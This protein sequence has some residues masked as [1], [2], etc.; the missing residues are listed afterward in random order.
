MSML[1]LCAVFDFRTVDMEINQA[2]R[3]YWL[4]KSGN[5][6]Q[7]Q[8]Q[9]RTS[10]GNLS[11][12]QQQKWLIAR[13][14]DLAT[15][16]GRPVRALEFGCGFGRFARL[17]ANNPHIEY[18]GYDFSLPMV[19][20]LFDDPPPSFN[21]SERV[22]VAPTVNEAF[23]D[24]KFDVIFTVSVLIHNQQEKAKQLCA[25][26]AAMLTEEGQLWL[27]ENALTALSTRENNWHGGC[28]VHDY[29]GTTAADM[30]I[31]VYHECIL[32]HS[33][34]VLQ[35]LSQP[36]KI[37]LAIGE[38]AQPRT[39]SLE[40][41]QQLGLPRLQAAIT[42]LDNE[43]AGQA[44]LQAMSH[45]LGEKVRS[46]T[47]EIR[48]LKEAATEA[49]NNLGEAVGSPL[50]SS[51]INSSVV[52]CTELKCR[53]ASANE[54]LQQLRSAKNLRS[55]IVDALNVAQPMNAKVDFSLSME[56]LTA[57][58]SDSVFD[59]DASQDLYLANPHEDF[60]SV[61]H[62][63]NREW[64]G[65]RAAAGALPGHKLA[66]SAKHPISA[67]DVARAVELLESHNI[68]KLVLQGMS[69]SMHSL[70]LGLA[71]KG[72]FDLFLVWHGAPAMWLNE[73]ERKLVGFAIELTRRGVIK[74]M[75]GMR[76]GT[77]PLIGDRAYPKLLLN[78]PPRI[79][80][81][82]PELTNRSARTNRV[83]F[84]PS[85][86][87][88]HKNVASSTLA[89]HVTPEIKEIWLLDDTVAKLLKYNSKV[90]TLGPRSGRA[91]LQTM[92]QADVVINVSLIDCHPM[93]DLEALAVGTPCVRGPLFLDA[94]EE[95]PYVRLTEVRN[96]LSVSDISKTITRIMQFPSNEL[97]AMMTD[98]RQ[99]LGKV[100]LSRYREFLEL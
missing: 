67:A 97:S 32:N 70:I 24:R 4:S 31:C 79:P 82:M 41:L 63:F 59:W 18:Y 14:D 47:E 21:P 27:I 28:W 37:E 87:L 35:P 38:N 95:H 2:N 39:S 33:A 75:H 43:V 90:K 55:K 80:N 56:K 84:I 60:D 1:L 66:I 29:A 46:L 62:V 23:G 72:K 65:I 17:F 93:V 68:K 13:F 34:Y 5:D 44:Q 77:E 96:I 69:E 25:E 54:Q 9:E 49:L 53:T 51:E 78:M 20:P 10:Q 16:V 36:R 64:I 12:T 58:P 40:E 74:G 57:I 81:E 86:H 89:A 6:Y 76:L 22:R 52:L 19:Q 73:H 15:R 99:E 7:W 30:D 91:M 61:C 50:E 85:W 48:T 71:K 98:Y 8:Q 83:A 26:M 94:L 100:S 3:N 88:L 11:Y 45:D 92:R 42:F